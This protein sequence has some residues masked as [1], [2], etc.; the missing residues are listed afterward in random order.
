MK[1]Y[2]NENAAFWDKIDIYESTDPVDADSV[3]NVPLKQL[4]DNALALKGGLGTA[5]SFMESVLGCAL[6]NM[7]KIRSM[8]EFTYE[9]ENEA[10]ANLVG[11]RF[12][13]STE[14]ALLPEDMAIVSGETIT[15]GEPKG[16]W[17]GNE[18]FLYSGHQEA[19]V[20][21]DGSR[22]ENE[23]LFLPEQYAAI[24][25]DETIKLAA[26]SFDG[27]SGG[28]GSYVL[29]TAT[30]TRLGGVK[31]GAGIKSEEDGTISVDARSS[32]EAAVGIIEATAYTPTDAEIDGLW[33]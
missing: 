3:D 28:S 19:I 18:K 27:P 7:E 22:L 29:P 30:A 23:T 11:C 32:A 5:Y 9:A 16:L 10:V 31:I 24:I 33:R 25:S 21:A 8:L 12:D 4:Q 15:I 26:A 6:A 1:K 17:I 14:T 20:G 13:E 2:T